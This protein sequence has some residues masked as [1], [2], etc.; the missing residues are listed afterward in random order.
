MTTPLKAARYNIRRP[1]VTKQLPPQPAQAQL[2]APDQSATEDH[3]EA[4]KNEGLTGRQLRMARRMAQRQGIAASS[5]FDA[6][7]QLRAAGIDPF[8][9]KDVLSGSTSAPAASGSAAPSGAVQLPQVAQTST[10]AVAAPAPPRDSSLE[11]RASEI[12]KMQRDIARRRRKNLF[13]LVARM[14]FFI[15]LPTL[16]AGY[17]FSRIATPMYATESEF[18]IQQASGQGAAAGGLGGLFQG[19]SMATQQDSITVQSYLTSIA[20]MQRLDEDHGFTSTFQGDDIDA[21]QRIAD[22]ATSSEAHNVYKKRI[23]ISYDPTE[24]L[25]RMEVSAPS[26]ELSYEFNT[27]LIGYAEE[28]VDQMTQRLRGDQM[29]GARD[30]YN[31]AEEQRTEALRILTKLQSEAETLDPQADN[32]ALMSRISALQKQGDSLNLELASLL[33]N[34][35]PNQAR[36]DGVRAS[37]RRVEAQIDDLRDIITE[38]GASGSSKNEVTAR[39]REAEENYQVRLALVQE[40]LAQMESARLEANRQVRYLSLSVPPTVPDSPS[41]PRAIENT[42]LAFAVF[43]ALYI[44]MSLT[45]AVLREQVAS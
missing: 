38:A 33:D 41:Y 45:A 16:I 15:G 27:A 35:R 13:L 44:L 23:K 17:Y 30:A 42:M 32:A 29:Q 39:I 6:V 40:S 10:M 12:R 9:R 34:A 21:L 36:V 1:Q 22:D 26:P 19:T 20:A 24:G 11:E 31:E 18:V 3:L 4:I 37:I 25:I 5:D 2:N 8:Q 7:H 14:L 43:F 28:R